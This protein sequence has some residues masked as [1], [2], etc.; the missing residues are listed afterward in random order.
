[1]FL[2]SNVLNITSKFE[3]D[4]AKGILRPYKLHFSFH[5]ENHTN[6]Y[7]QF[8]IKPSLYHHQFYKPGAVRIPKNGF[9]SM[10][11]QYFFVTT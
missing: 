9:E 5:K 7:N 11:L 6:L 4:T 10:I 3:L 8:L 1:M 2:F